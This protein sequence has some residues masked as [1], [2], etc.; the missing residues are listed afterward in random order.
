MSIHTLKNVRLSFPQLFQPQVQQDGKK[1]YGASFLF[2]ANHPAKAEIT[3][4]MKAVAKDKW[5]NKAD[6]ELNALI[7]GGRVCLRDGATK[8]YAGYQDNWFVSASNKTRPQVID[9]DTSP[10]DESSGRPYGGC[11]VVASIEIWAQDNAYGKRINATLRWIQF[12]G[13]GES[14]GGGTPVNQDE[15]AALADEAYADLV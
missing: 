1:T 4:A 2:S 13:D 5:G 7:A 15:F 12:A 9:K 3:A 14:F 8:A 6:A 11:F 10:L